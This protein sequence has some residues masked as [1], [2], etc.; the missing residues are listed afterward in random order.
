MLTGPAERPACVQPCSAEEVMKK[1]KSLKV[2][3]FEALAVMLIYKERKS[4]QCNRILKGLFIWPGFLSM[5]FPF[6]GTFPLRML[7]PLW[8]NHWVLASAAC[9]DC[10]SKLSKGKAG[11]LRDWPRVIQWV[12]RRAWD[13][14]ITS[15]FSVLGL[16][17]YG[18]FVGG[19]LHGQAL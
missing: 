19:W 4:S 17:C 14:T 13:E 16:N 6:S 1:V 2:F 9:E 11:T 8:S 12:G 5:L 3:S 10:L 15:W 7:K 18:V